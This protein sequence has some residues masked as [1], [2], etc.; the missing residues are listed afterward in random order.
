MRGE[1]SEEFPIT[2]KTGK[3]EGKEKTNQKARLSLKNDTMMKSIRWRN[4]MMHSN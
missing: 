3:E 2:M 1:S 4:L